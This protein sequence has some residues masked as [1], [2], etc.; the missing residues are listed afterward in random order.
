MRWPLLFLSSAVLFLFFQTSVQAGA[1]HDAVLSENA[2][3]VAASLASGA[4]VNEPGD[5]GTPLHLAA[6]VGN[7]AL[8]QRLIDAH[9][10]V[11]ARFGSTAWARC[12]PRRATATPPSPRC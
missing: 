4:D 1:L 10:D 2:D 12:T 9:A 6:F 5:L 3:A 11:E 8:A 7:A